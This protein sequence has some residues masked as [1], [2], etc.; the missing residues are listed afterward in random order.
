[1]HIVTQF[2]IRDRVYIDGCRGLVGMITGVIA[3]ATD[4][5]IYEV[6]WIANG[7]SQDVQLEEWRLTKVPEEKND[8]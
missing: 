3:R 1:M 6:G 5:T 2:D 7:V 4:R 8:A